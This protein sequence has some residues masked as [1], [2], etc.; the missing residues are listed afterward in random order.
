M[1][2]WIEYRIPEDWKKN[3]IVPLHK[4][5][6]S[7]DCN[8]YRAICLASVASKIYTRIIERRLRIVVEE[9]MEE[10]QGA[11]RP[12]NQ[13]Q[14]HIYTLRAIMEKNIAK[15]RDMYVAFLDLRLHLTQYRDNIYGKHW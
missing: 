7:N 14:D 15:N 2:C 5:G 4:N 8:N 1:K 10:E 13:T 9:D 12:E 6:S 11:F 3:L